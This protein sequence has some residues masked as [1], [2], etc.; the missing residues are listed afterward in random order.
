MEKLNDK[1][2]EIMMQLRESSKLCATSLLRFY[3]IRFG[4]SI[5]TLRQ[6][7]DVCNSK[8][9]IQILVS[10]NVHYSSGGKHEISKTYNLFT[11]H[12]FHL[13][14]IEHIWYSSLES[15]KLKPGE[16]WSN[17][18]VWQPNRLRN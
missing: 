6:V 14:C 8:D 15:E 10:V 18:K 13:N 9:A 16:N 7:D 17:V 1:T 4:C 3:Q 5:S 12:A 11:T 2:I